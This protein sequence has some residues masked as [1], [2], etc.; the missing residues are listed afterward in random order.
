MPLLFG[1]ALC[2]R[3]RDRKARRFRRTVL[4]ALIAFSLS[5]LAL[6]GPL[7]VLCVGSAL[8]DPSRGL[9]I[10]AIRL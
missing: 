7:R 8:P 5:L 9:F 2:T 6:S 4:L 3:L 1:T 10:L